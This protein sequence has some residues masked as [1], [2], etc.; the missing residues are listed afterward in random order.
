MRCGQFFVTETIVKDYKVDLGCKILILVGS[1]CL[2]TATE[3]G[4]Q[5]A[6][7][8]VFCMLEPTT[9]CVQLVQ[10]TGGGLNAC[11]STAEYDSCQ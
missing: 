4:M 7:D 11:S 6:A 10:V 3:Y 8:D 9:V 1:C 5:L 2:S